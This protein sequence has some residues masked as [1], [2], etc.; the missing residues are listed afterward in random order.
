M[1]IPSTVVAVIVTYEPDLG[2]FGLQSRRLSGQVARSIIVDNGSTPDT[3]AR[4]RELAATPGDTVELIELGRNLG[5]AAAQNVGI[6]RALAGGATHVLLMDHDSTP[7]PDMVA[8]LLAACT[9]LTCEGRRVAAVGPRYLDERQANPPPFIRVS[10]LRLRRLGCP[11]E[12]TVVAVDYLIA[13][14]SLIPR[15]TL[16]RVGPMNEALFIDYVDIEWGLRA[17]MAGFESFGV[18]AAAMAHDLG[19][20]PIR[21]LGRALPSH[22]A[23]RHYYHFRNAVWLY[24]HSRVPIRWKLVDAYRLVLRFGFYSCFARP[25]LDHVLGMARGI[26]D[27]VLGRLGPAR[28]VA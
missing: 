7:A 9:R 20:A 11:T 28:Q 26:R 13:S 18:C 25:R 12:A 15:D 5:I 8:R 17:G 21:V 6:D 24:V 3:L 10:G 14:G 22:S 16:E 27:G 4:L 23:L 2:R 1:P 19:D